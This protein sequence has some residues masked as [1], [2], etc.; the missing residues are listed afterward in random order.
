M[1]GK[2]WFA[3]LMK[4]HPEISVRL[5]E[6]TSIN[7][8]TAFNEIAVGN[9]FNDLEPFIAIDLSR[10]FNLDET[11]ISTVE[12]LSKILAKR[13]KARVAVATSGERGTN[14]TVVCCMSA[15]RNFVSPMYIFKRLRM[16][17]HF[18]NDAPVG[19]IGDCSESGWVNEN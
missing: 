15:I 17:E 19:S 1:V 2:E 5:P 14:T 11:K 10:I 4:S 12:R 6:G 3:A 13:G 9:F 18:M 8:A 16:A 7:C